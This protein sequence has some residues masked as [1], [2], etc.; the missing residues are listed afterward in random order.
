MSRHTIPKTA[1]VSSCALVTLGLLLTD[2]F[3]LTMN[4]MTLIV[5]SGLLLAS[6]VVFAGLLWQEKAADE[7]EVSLIDTAGRLGF[8]AGLSVLV[9]G[10]VFQ[11]FNHSVDPWMVVAT[12]A[13]IISKHAYLGAKK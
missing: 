8:L 5:I 11:S 12:A 3:D 7:R 6:F 1:L 4:N 2:P 9:V 13:M 10:I